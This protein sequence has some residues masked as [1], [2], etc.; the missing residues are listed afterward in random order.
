MRP[1]LHQQIRA[2]SNKLVSLICVFQIL[3]ESR[4]SETSTVF[5]WFDLR[6]SETMVSLIRKFADSL[7]YEYFSLGHRRVSVQRESQVL[8]NAESSNCDSRENLN[9]ETIFL[10]LQEFASW[11]NFDH[12]PPSH[13][14]DYQRSSFCRIVSK[15][16]AHL[17]YWLNRLRMVGYSFRYLTFP[18]DP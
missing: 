15:A 11:S 8:I 17:L 13:F 16:A 4:I 10:S 14:S 18:L 6:I 12:R 9:S 2:F 3:S 5:R 1:Y 7:P